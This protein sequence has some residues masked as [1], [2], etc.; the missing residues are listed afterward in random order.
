MKKQIELLKKYLIELIE[1][2]E[3]MPTIFDITKFEKLKKKINTK[4]QIRRTNENKY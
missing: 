3:K 4:T 1:L 2:T